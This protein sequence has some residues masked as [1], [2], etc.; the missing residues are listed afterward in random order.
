VA[1]HIPHRIHDFKP[2]QPLSPARRVGGRVSRAPPPMS[3]SVKEQSQL[4]VRLLIALT[5]CRRKNPGLRTAQGAVMNHQERGAHRLYA[6]ACHARSPSP[7]VKEACAADVPAS[8]QALEMR[9]LPEGGTLVFS[10][11]I[12]VWNCSS[13]LSQSVAHASRPGPIG[14]VPLGRPTGRAKERR[15]DSP[16]HGHGVQTLQLDGE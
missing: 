2:R 11:E 6:R 1:R 9:A 15:A 8:L 4:A 5:A 14:Q 12:A 7:A 13:A 3:R 10:G 16:P